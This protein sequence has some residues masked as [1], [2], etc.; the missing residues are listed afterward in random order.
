MGPRAGDFD[1]RLLVDVG[2]SRHPRNFAVYRGFFRAKICDPSHWLV[3]GGILDGG[4]VPRHGGLRR[5]GEVGLD[6]DPGRVETD[7]REAVERVGVVLSPRGGDGL[8]MDCGGALDGWSGLVFGRRH[9]ALDGRYPS[10]GVGDSAVRAV[11]AVVL[12]GYYCVL[13]GV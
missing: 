1:L 3:P 7:G 4:S 11:D 13:L 10:E 9:G 5:G 8:D 2:V 6:C 12:R